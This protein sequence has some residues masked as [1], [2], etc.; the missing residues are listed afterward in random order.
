MAI[1]RRI[2]LEFVCWALTFALTA[3]SAVSAP[4]E[5][6]AS[7]PSGDAKAANSETQSPGSSAAGENKA[8]DSGAANSEDIDTRITVQ[9]HAPPGKAGKLGGTTSR[10]QPLKLVNPHRRIFSPSRAASRVS[11]NASGILNGQREI[12]QHGPGEHFES[13]GVRLTPNVGALTG[14]GNANISLAKPGSTLMREPIFHS[15]TIPP[16]GLGPK[17]HTG[18]GGPTSNHHAVG[19]SPVG[20]GGPARS[21]NGINGTSI[22]ES[23]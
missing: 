7:Q 22:R 16:L 9:P 3:S 23:R 6:A 17:N 15:P 8:P 13:N 5:E 14:A 20:I 18:V 12:L 11:P 21:V 2:K 1:E 19:A 4:A 10:I